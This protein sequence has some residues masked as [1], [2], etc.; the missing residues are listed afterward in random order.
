MRATMSI[1]GLLNF[2]ND[3]FE[4]MVVPETID[5]E[6]LV[7]NIVEECAELELLFPSALTMKAILPRWSARRLPV[8]N[9]ISE[10]LTAEY[11]LL[12]NYDRT[13]TWTDSREGSRTSSG[14]RNVNRDGDNVHAETVTG[15]EQ[16]TTTTSGTDDSTVTRSGTEN[17]T[18]TTSGT[19]DISI[20]K[21]ATEDRTTTNTGTDD[22]TLTKSGTES[23]SIT[24]HS[25]SETTGSVDTDE[26][27]TNS[28]VGY[29]SAAFVNHDKSVKDGTVATTSGTTTDG[30]ETDS[31]TSSG[32]E[33]TDRDTTGKEVIDGESTGTETTD[34][35]TTGREAVAGESSATETT[36][37]ETAG[38]ETINGTTG[39]TRRLTDTIDETDA[40]TTA[41]SESSEDE[42]T[43]N[44]HISGNIGVTTSQQMIEAEITL[45]MVYDLYNIITQEFK[46]K[47]C[48]MVY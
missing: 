17:R 37:S 48:I 46:E 31:G 25:E 9:R 20:T 35:D 34:R 41:G 39:G 3:L 26:T 1:L 18:T 32:T 24:T 45:R 44:G 33:T 15:T 21:S 43:H 22:I 47:F 16:R 30:T 38:T 36:E 19:D 13:E 2:D 7:D 14:T 4:D 11:N 12:H 28:V 10:A 5:K 27:V 42:S 40:E 29:D 23:K 8:W 6:K